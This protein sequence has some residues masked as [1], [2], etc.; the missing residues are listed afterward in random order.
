MVLSLVFASLTVLL[1]AL[2]YP[3]SLLCVLGG[4]LYSKTL[5]EPLGILVS[6]IVTSV[7]TTVRR[8]PCFIVSTL[9]AVAESSRRL[10]R[11]SW[12]GLHKKVFTH[13]TSTRHVVHVFYAEPFC[14]AVWWCSWAACCRSW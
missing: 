7:A 5:G 4:Y 9:I 2:G 13:L 8:L 14:P 6:T 12:P 3:M 1:V 10:G 11:N